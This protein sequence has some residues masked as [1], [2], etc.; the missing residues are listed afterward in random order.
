MSAAAHLAFFLIVCGAAAGS[1]LCAWA[2]RLVHGESIV[3]PPSRCRCCGTRIGWL[4]KVPVFSWLWLAGKCR[5]C[6]A[7]IPKQVFYCELAGVALA[8][9]AVWVA[10]SP[11]HMALGA[12]WLWTLMGLMV[13]DLSVF[14]LPDAL[15]GLLLMTGFG[16]AWEDPGRDLA[17]AF[18]GAGVGAGVFLALRIAYRAL[19]G[20]EGLG[21][22]DVKMMAGIGAGLGAM[23]LPVVTLTA[24]VLAL[25]V[26]L[27]GAVWRGARPGGDQAIAFGA[28]LALA[29]ALVW[30][31]P[32]V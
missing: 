11:M 28:Y 19:R 17:G 22:G 1:F 32:A 27:L 8:V 3:S 18:I 10:Q 9:V 5:T 20:R 16:L 13:C 30:V 12:I 21:L 23:A 7:K 4:D 6:G 25:G 2:D 29:A 14:R 31:W 24:A 26:A 15:T